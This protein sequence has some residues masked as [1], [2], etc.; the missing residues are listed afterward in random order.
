[1]RDL[2]QGIGRM[3]GWGKGDEYERG[4]RRKIRRS[5]KVV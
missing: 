5:Q 2:N 3:D 4:L 1:M